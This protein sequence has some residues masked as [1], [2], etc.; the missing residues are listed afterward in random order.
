MVVCFL[1][2]LF[3]S[4]LVLSDKDKRAIYDIYGQKGLDADWQVHY[5]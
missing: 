3:S 5:K 4:I 1:N 2:K